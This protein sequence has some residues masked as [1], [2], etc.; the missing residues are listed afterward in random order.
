MG[1]L[2]NCSAT[3]NVV[4][5]GGDGSGKTTLVNRMV[6][7]SQG[8]KFD[9][10]NVV[11]PTP[12]RKIRRSSLRHHNNTINVREVPKCAQP[13][14][15]SKTDAIIYVIDSTLP[16]KGL[17]AEIEEA[18]RVTCPS[19]GKSVILPTILVLSKGDLWMK[20]P[21]NTSS[22]VFL[23]EVM[24][25][26]KATIGSFNKTV[27]PNIPLHIIWTDYEGGGCQSVLDTLSEELEK[28]TM[29]GGVFFRESVIP[30][31]A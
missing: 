2:L 6:D 30:S 11:P 18:V 13:A 5:F 25:M 12:S 9:K 16:P 3:Y 20:K 19:D 10:I 22:R 31:N 28:N 29:G 17:K 23:T 21:E 4:V 14:Y 1:N 26:Y 24:E 7:Y 8:C 15:S 27:W